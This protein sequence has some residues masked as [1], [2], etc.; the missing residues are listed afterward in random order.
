MEKVE[1][2]YRL[3]LMIS[4]IGPKLGT[5]VWNSDAIEATITMAF[6]FQI[7][8]IVLAINACKLAKEKK[9]KIFSLISVLYA[10]LCALPLAIVVAL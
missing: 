2:F 4:I 5:C 1:K 9:D 8:A 7:I 3:S 10:S 6:G